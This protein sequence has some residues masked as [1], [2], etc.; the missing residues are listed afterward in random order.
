MIICL[1]PQPDC[2]AD[3]SALKTRGLAATAL[4]LL[5][6]HYHNGL[7][8]VLARP[9]TI[10]ACQGIIITS[11]QA[12]RYLAAH[13]GDLNG[14]TVLPIWCVGKGSADI[15][16]QAGYK[17]VFD[18]SGGARELAAR[19][20]RDAET[21]NGPFL[22]LSGRD[23]SVDIAASLAGEGV[24]VDRLVIYQ[25]DALSRP[26]KTV[27]DRLASAEPVA[28]MVFSARTLAQFSFWLA[29]HAPGKDKADITVLAASSGLAEQARRA[30]FDARHAARPDRHALLQLCCDW[31]EQNKPEV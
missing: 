31:S 9:E 11:K 25:A 10:N 28:A 23:V 5:A 22:W 6:I 20:A 26:D 3:V 1:R 16:R 19:I 24:Q 17:A 14:L 29:Q 12:S 8:D 7:L 15:L 2:D 13:A 18:G 30:G 21:R 4:P 27:Q